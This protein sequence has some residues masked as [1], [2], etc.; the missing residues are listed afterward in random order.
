MAP[1]GAVMS[2]RHVGEVVGEVV[3]GNSCRTIGKDVV[4]DLKD[5]LRHVRSW[6]YMMFTL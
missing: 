2:E 4:L 6:P 5:L 3:D 1:E